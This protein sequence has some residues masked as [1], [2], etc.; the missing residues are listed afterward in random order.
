MAGRASRGHGPRGRWVLDSVPGDGQPPGR[1]FYCTGPRLKVLSP[2]RIAHP[3]VGA[4]VPLGR[5]MGAGVNRADSRMMGERR[6]E[7][8]R[9]PTPV[10]AGATGGVN[11]GPICDRRATE[12]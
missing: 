10:L 2:D 1:T 12:F 8:A 11:T 9:P 7:S 3:A 5:K 4:R 6:S